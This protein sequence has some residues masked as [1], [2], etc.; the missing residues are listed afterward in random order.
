GVERGIDDRIDADLRAQF[1]SF[2]AAPQRDRGTEVPAGAVAGDGDTRAVDAELAGVRHD[3]RERGV[4]V[5]EWD[6]DRML[7]RQPV[8]D[9]EHRSTRFHREATSDEVVRLDVTAHEP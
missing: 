8:I 2:D 9:T 5:V 6:R 4:T 1:G 3:P 7:R